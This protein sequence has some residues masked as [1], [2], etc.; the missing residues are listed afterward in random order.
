MAP[1]KVIIAGCGIA[2]P[3]LGIFLRLKGYDPVIYERSAEPTTL[4]LSLCL[5]PNGL[6]V[7]NL[8]PGLLEKVIGQDLDAFAMYSVLPGDEGTIVWSDLPSTLRDLYGYSMKGVRRPV[9]HRTLVEH[10]QNHGI[11]IVWGHQLVSVDQ[12]ADSVQ[13]GF[14]NGAKDTASFVVG[15]DGLHSNTRICLFGEENA[16]YTGLTQTG[17]VSPK[18]DFLKARHP[19]TDL[20][21]DGSH[22]IYY[23]VNDSQVSWA[24]TRKEAEAKETW[25]HMDEHVQQEFREHG[26]CST[27]GFG[28]KEL[29]ETAEHIVKY[30][31]YDRPELKAWHKGRVALLGDAAHPTSPHLGQGANQAFEDIYHF[32]RLLVKHNPSAAGPST[33]VLQAVFS[34]YETIRIPR[35]SALVQGARKRGDDRVLQGAEERKKR[36]ELIKEHWND[37]S[38]IAEPYRQLFTQPFVGESEI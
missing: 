10:A 2:G 25:R 26:P 11:K 9:F 24:F 33:D 7:I 20:F 27:W 6:R 21:G 29:V 36:N 34:E 8:I 31:L 35:T 19:M 1:T 37:E 3:V 12:H 17:G 22:M 18:P 14:T 38:T 30:G 28:A 15:C 13:V 16:D 23:Q 4:G 5:Q 32:I